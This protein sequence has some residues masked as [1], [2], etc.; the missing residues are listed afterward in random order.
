M[1]LKIH[2]NLRTASLNPKF[3]GSNKKC[4][5]VYQ[6]MMLNL[7]FC[8]EERGAFRFTVIIPDPL[9]PICYPPCS[10]ALTRHRV[11]LP[12]LYSVLSKLFGGIL[13]LHPR[14]I[15]GLFSQCLNARPKTNSQCLPSCFESYPKVIEYF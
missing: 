11:A 10:C 7:C 2:E 13:Q 1:R 5:T 3:R 4:I 9:F 6:Q 12:R 14:Q 8:D 15:P